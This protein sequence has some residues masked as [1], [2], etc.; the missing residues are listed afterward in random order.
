MATANQGWRRDRPRTAPRSLRASPGPW[1][2]CTTAKVPMMMKVPM[3]KMLM[4]LKMK[5][6]MLIM[7]KKMTMTTI[8]GIGAQCWR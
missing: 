4:M 3:M 8:V 1:I 5:V 6:P 7:I 2:T